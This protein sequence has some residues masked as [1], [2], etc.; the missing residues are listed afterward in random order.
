MKLFLSSTI[1][2]GDF[3]LEVG[4]VLDPALKRNLETIYSF[5]FNFKFVYESYLLLNIRQMIYEF[6]LKY[7]K[8]YFVTMLIKLTCKERNLYGSV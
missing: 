5:K 3:V 1:V 2:A 7:F 6:S 4:R 8:I